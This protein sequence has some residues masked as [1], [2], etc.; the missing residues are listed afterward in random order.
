MIINN[1]GYNHAHDADFFI[2]RPNG[3]N[4]YLLLLLKTPSIFTLNNCDVHVPENSFFLYKKGSPQYYRCIEQSIFSNDW[5]HFDFENN[6]LQ[7]FLEFNI[8]FDTPVPMKNISFLSFCIKSIAY[9]SCS[10]NKNKDINI[11]NFMSLIFSKVDEQLSDCTNNVT[12]EKFEMLSTIRN[13]IYA[14]P[15]ENKCIGYAAHEVRMSESSFQ[16]LYKQQFGVTFLQDLI[17]A[18][19]EHA[20]MLLLT[21]NLP[22]VEVS[23]Q[24]G[25]H[26]YA[27]FTR[28][29][30]KVV[31]LPPIDFRLQKK[32]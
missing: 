28:Q 17:N 18:R 12:N 11:L 24:C 14:K 10:L 9:E 25:Y 20:K 31:G 27:H 8:P 23:K 29:F 1:V 22:S 21:T 3:S 16:H 26:S 19:I 30:K 13:K 5:I 15:Y 2:S 32:S 7:K 4:D 6:E